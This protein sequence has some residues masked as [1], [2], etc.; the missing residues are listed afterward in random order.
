MPRPAAN[1]PTAAAGLP[2][3]R[4]GVDLRLD[5]NQ[6]RAPGAA[7]ADRLGRDVELLRCYPFEHALEEQLA[8]RH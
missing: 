3:A 1:V 7:F 5:G 2:P 6:G 4:P 8:A